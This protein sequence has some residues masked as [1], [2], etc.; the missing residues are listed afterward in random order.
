[1]ETV[2]ANKDIE[3]YISWTYIVIFYPCKA[4]SM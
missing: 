4:E 1:M 3:M 2:S